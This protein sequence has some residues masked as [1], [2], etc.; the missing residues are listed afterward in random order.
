MN[1]LVTGGCGFIGHHFVEHIL[2]NTD[3]NIII[4]DKLSYASFGLDRISEKNICPNL[5]NRSKRLKFYCWDLITP[6][7]SGLIGVLGNIN[8]IVHMAADTHVDNSIKNPVEVVTNNILSTLNL[9]EY[10]RL[11]NNLKLFLYFS[12]DEVYGTALGNKAFKEGETHNPSN[13][14][15][16]SKSCG[17]QLCISYINTYNLPITRINVMNA[18]GERQHP[19]KF[20]PKVINSLLNNTKLYIHCYPGCVIPGS[21]YYIHARN[22][23]SAVLFIIKNG[24]KNESYNITGEKEIDNLALALEIAKIMD[25]PLNYDLVDYHDTRPGYDLRYSLNSD[26]LK[27]LGWEI[28]CTFHESLTKTIQWTLK[29]KEWLKF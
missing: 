16:A 17:E 6:L 24:K 29:N 21:R 19:E 12:T 26:K 7:S 22:I 2:L 14:Y 9:L 18:M 8:I 10:S 1:I 3:Y 27:E 13:P 11:L 4:I 20:I 15:S 25:K 23:S 28:P 5:E